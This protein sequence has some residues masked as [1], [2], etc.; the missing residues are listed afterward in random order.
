MSYAIID[1]VAGGPAP[2]GIYAYLDP[3]VP[4]MAEATIN[5]TTTV[6]GMLFELMSALIALQ[7]TASG[8]MLKR[9]IAGSAISSNVVVTPTMLKR[10]LA[11]VTIAPS[12]TIISTMLKRS[13]SNVTISSTSFAIPTM[14]EK[15][16][17]RA[18]IQSS[19]VINPD[20]FRKKGP[21]HSV[22]LK[23]EK[24]Q[25]ILSIEGS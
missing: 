25:I 4:A 1:V 3:G 12:V 15:A 9:S 2:T 6:N 24:Y 22:T 14:L 20:I 23:R 18:A 16:E 10:G 5:S 13:I 21:F 11:G 19:V 8:S 17:L 7:S